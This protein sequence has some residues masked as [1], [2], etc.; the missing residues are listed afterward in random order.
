MSRAS[1]ERSRERCATESDETREARL[2]RTIVRASCFLKLLST[3]SVA[4]NNIHLDMPSGNLR[5]FKFDVHY[6]D[7]GGLSTVVTAGGL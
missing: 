5:P 1:T 7:G 4:Q 2:R 3:I 6:F